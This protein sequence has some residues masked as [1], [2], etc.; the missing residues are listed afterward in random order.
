MAID[1]DLLA[2]LRRYD[3][4]ELGI[5]EEFV[6]QR[7]GRTGALGILARP[8]GE[9]RSGAWVI[10]PSLG[11]EQASLR[12]LESLV[13]RTL[14][15]AGLPALRIRDE[16]ERVRGLSLSARL[17]EVEDAVGF[18]RDTFGVARVGLAGALFGGTVAALVCD[19]LELADLVLWEPVERGDRYVRNA[20]RFQRIAGLV[21][22]P[23]GSQ[24]ERAE[25][26]GD[27]LARQGFTVVRGFRLA[28]ADYDD[29]NA[30]SLTADV[31]RYQGRSLLVGVSSSGAVSPSLQ[32]LSDHLTA[33]GGESRLEVVQDE[34]VT[35]FGE[36]YYRNVGVVRIDTRLELDRKLAQLTTAWAVDGVAVAGERAP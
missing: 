31:R 35:P 14:A 33:L 34:L 11:T 29:I 12:R 4:H 25:S 28:Q 26:A 6:V 19:R 17:S 32:R 24:P 8:L 18:M 13:A 22:S 20:L 23:T 1:L 9:P 10:C 2:E 16:G 15:A 3:D 27:E 7:L 5:A 21:G 36:H 30:V